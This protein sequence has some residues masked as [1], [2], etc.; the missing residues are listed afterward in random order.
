MGVRL[1][2][3]LTPQMRDALE[4]LEAAL[5]AE[6]LQAH[7]IVATVTCKKTTITS[8]SS[9]VD[10]TAGLVELEAFPCNSDGYN[11]ARTLMARE[12]ERRT[13]EVPLPLNVHTDHD[14]PQAGISND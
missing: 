9:H 1:S 5:V 10:V 11:T 13:G 4:A 6:P 7:V 2:G 14:D 8:K 3:E 12:R